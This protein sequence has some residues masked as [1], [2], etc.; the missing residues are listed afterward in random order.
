MEKNSD[1]SVNGPSPPQRPPRRRTSLPFLTPSLSSL[2][3]SSSTSSITVPKTL[4]QLKGTLTRALSQVIKSSHHRQRST[5]TPINRTTETCSSSL[6]LP[7]VS[8][9]LYPSLPSFREGEPSAPPLLESSPSPVHSN[10]NCREND[11]ENIWK[12]RGRKSASGFTVGDRVKV[13]VETETQLKHLQED[14]GGWHPRMSRLLGREGTVHRITDAGDIR[15]RF[16]DTR[17]RWTFNPEALTKVEHD[18]QEQIFENYIRLRTNSSCS[19]TTNCSKMTD[20]S[21]TSPPS[22]EQETLKRLHYLESK[23]NEMEDYFSCAICLERVKS[24]V[25]LCGHSACNNCA[26]GL[27]SCHMCREPIVRKIHVY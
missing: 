10:E 6:F 24:V 2:P 25:F 18:K 5:I 15:V 12:R 23:V 26:E 16:P 27:D 19:R 7:P 11:H 20:V 4:S 9:S 21:I 22:H 17:L 8:T 13:S 1:S 14:H 3:S